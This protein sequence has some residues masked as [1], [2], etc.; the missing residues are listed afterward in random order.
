VLA[1]YIG[2]SL[3]K[4]EYYRGSAEDCCRKAVMAE[5]VDRRSHWLEAAAR[6]VSLARQEGVLL[7]RK[8]IKDV[9]PSN[10]PVLSKAGTKDSF[11]RA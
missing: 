10:D 7:P 3:S 2:M 8:S 5:D 11:L 1:G 9:T 4:E 6:W